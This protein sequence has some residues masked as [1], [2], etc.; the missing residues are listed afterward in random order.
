MKSN[1]NWMDMS[2]TP[3]NFFPGIYYTADLTTDEHNTVM[4]EA[5]RSAEYVHYSAGCAAEMQAVHDPQVDVVDTNSNRRMA[6]TALR[7]RLK[8]LVAK[9]PAPEE[10][11]PVVGV[12]V[13][14]VDSR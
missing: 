6:A 8:Q 2:R 4:D 9:L 12:G 11:G 7:E 13:L 1:M 10:D 14:K 3:R 5:L